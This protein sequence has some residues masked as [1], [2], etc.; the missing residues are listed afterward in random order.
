GRAGS[1][2]G[3]HRRGPLRP[4]PGAGLPAG[5][6]PE[7]G[8]DG[9]PAAALRGEGRPG[10]RGRDAQDARRG[11]RA[12]GAQGFGYTCR[13]A[14]GVS[15]RPLRR[16]GRAPDDARGRRRPRR[17]HEEEGEA[18]AGRPPGRRRDAAGVPGEEGGPL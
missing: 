9:V 8:P 10:G 13:V 15:R 12:A 5:G 4:R 2:G 3:P 14:A 17:G 18:R 1:R 11:G 6:C 16:V 7:R